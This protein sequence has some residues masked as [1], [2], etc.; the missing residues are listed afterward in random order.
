[1]SKCLAPGKCPLDGRMGEW[2]DGEDERFT[3]GH[4]GPDSSLW[5]PNNS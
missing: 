1:M 4:T 3:P 5:A 2:M